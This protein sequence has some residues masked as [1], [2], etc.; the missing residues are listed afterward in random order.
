[1]ADPPRRMFDA[2]T[3]AGFFQT[4]AFP[5]DSDSSCSEDDLFDLSDPETTACVYDSPIDAR[6][7]SDEAEDS[8]GEAGDSSDE[9][10]VKQ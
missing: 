9:A 7:S 5:I 3:V 4:E 1:M 6:H 2:A 10:V 8:N